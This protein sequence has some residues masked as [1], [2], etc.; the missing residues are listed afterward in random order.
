MYE[1]ILV[2]G[3]FRLT[4]PETMPGDSPA[5]DVAGLVDAPAEFLS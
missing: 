4:W 2:T 3:D 5:E 1:A